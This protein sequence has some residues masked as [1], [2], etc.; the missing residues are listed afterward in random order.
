MTVATHPGLEAVCRA[1]EAGQAPRSLGSRAMFEDFNL[2]TDH[3]WVSATAGGHGSPM[4]YYYCLGGLVRALAP[5]SV[6]EIG[7]GFGLGASTILRAGAPGLRRLVT[8]D[9][10][11][12]EDGAAHV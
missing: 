7:T 11:L 5:E 2:T 8:V 12:Y 4:N 1:L 9:L 3:P 6:L 10:D